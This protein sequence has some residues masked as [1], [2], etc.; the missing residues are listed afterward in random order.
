MVVSHR[1][2]EMKL[3]IGNFEVRPGLQE[4]AAFGEVRRHRPGSL[5]PVL[6]DRAQQSRQGLERDAVEVGIV[7]HV[8]EHEIRMV[9]Q[10][11][12]DAGQVMHGGDAVLSHLS[13]VADAR[14]HQQ[15]RGLECAGRDDDLAPGADLL[16]RLALPVF[17]AD[18][19]LAF[20]QDAGGVRAGLDA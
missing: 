14:E 7:R 20:E 12:S 4:A 1:H 6:A 16:Q 13:A 19:A 2:A 18:R 5:A 17:D 15:L 8:A 9:L 10:V 11:L 3:D